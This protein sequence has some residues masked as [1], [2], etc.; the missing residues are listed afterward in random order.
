MRD[1][2]GGALVFEELGTPTRA[3]VLGVARRAAERVD[4]LLRKSGRRLEREADEPEP[5]L[6]LDE[7]GLASCYAAA[8]RGISVSGERTGL[9]S[10]ASPA[11][12]SA[13]SPN[14]PAKNS[15][16]R[17]TGRA[18]RSAKERARA[19]A[20]SGLSGRDAPQAL[21][22]AKQSVSAEGLPPQLPTLASKD[23]QV[24]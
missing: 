6:L 17:D 5:E 23:D 16:A 24:R 13:P 2:D 12:S 11:S 3:E 9:P 19:A 8:A 1:A 18:R 14:S 15:R 20:I 4:R 7:P 21:L 10:T 22:D